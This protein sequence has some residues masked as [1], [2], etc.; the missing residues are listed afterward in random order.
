MADES[1]YVRAVVDDIA[2]KVKLDELQKRYDHALM[3]AK[4]SGNILRTALAAGVPYTMAQEMAGD[5]WAAE[6]VAHGL[7]VVNEDQAPDADEEDGE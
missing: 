3:V 7:I 5:F 1:E 6:Y 2:D 4:G